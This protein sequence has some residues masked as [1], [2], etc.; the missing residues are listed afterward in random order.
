MPPHPFVGKAK[1]IGQTASLCTISSRENDGKTLLGQPFDNWIKKRNV[2]RI[3]QIYPD[4]FIH[5]IPSRKQHMG[6]LYWRLYV[7]IKHRI[8]GH[9]TPSLIVTTPGIIKPTPIHASF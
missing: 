3:F 9:S 2:W 1:A 7:F 4:R 8:C 5:N 6:F